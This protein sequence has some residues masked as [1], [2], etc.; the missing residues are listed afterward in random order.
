[1][2]KPGLN[3][4]MISFQPE[5]YSFHPQVI[6]SFNSPGDF[7]GAFVPV[8]C[9]SLTKSKAAEEEVAKPVTAGFGV[10]P[11]HRRPC[12]HISSKTS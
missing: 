1:M 3:P 4:V 2:V 6:Y 7:H 8:S 5:A 9:V 11:G 10:L 12:G